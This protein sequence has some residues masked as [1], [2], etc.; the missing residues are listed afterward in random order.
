[1]NEPHSRREVQKSEKLLGELITHI[2]LCF[3][4][5]D[6][7]GWNI[8]KM[9]ALAKMPTNM[10]KF[11]TANNFCGQIDDRALKGIVKDHAQQT[12]R[13]PDLF[14]QQCELREYETNLLRYVMSD[15]DG[16]CGL[17]TDGGGVDVVCR[18]V[19]A[20]MRA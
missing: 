2:K 3:P 20:A 8:P 4:R 7:S 19:R 10:L 14:D 12:Q 18:E 6:G 17:S 5:T 15:I 9:H 13:M 11:G 16:Q 1:V